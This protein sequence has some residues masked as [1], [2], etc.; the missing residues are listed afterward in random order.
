MFFDIGLALDFIESYHKKIVDAIWRKASMRMDALLSPAQ[1]QSIGQAN[2]GRLE[3]TRRN[4]TIG[5]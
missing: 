1:C 2:Y 3:P 4:A 5:A